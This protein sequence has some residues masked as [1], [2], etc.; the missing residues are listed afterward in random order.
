MAFTC[1]AF[2]PPAILPDLPPFM[3]EPDF[4]SLLE[5]EDI[6]PDVLPE[7]EPEDIEPELLPAPEPDDIEPDVLPEPDAPVPELVAGLELGLA[8]D[9]DFVS[10]PVVAG[11]LVSALEPLPPVELPVAPALDEEPAPEPLAPLAP[12]LWANAD[13]ASIAPATVSAK[14]LIHVFI[15]VL[16]LR[17]GC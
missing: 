16:L 4:I 3:A 11:V 10:L 8:D 2:P 14:A 5:P 12:P 6:E 7:P 9:G 1:S 13:V 15:T 17:F